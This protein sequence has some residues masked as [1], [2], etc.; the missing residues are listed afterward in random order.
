MKNNNPQRLS[1][2]ENL[3]MLMVIKS[4]PLIQGTIT[5]KLAGYLKKNINQENI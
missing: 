2:R 5:T 3:N 1:K 4:L